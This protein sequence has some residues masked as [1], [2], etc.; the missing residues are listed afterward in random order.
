MNPVVR[1]ILHALTPLVAGCQTASPSL[2]YLQQLKEWMIAHPTEL[3]VLWSS[4]HG[5]NRISGNDAVPGH[6]DTYRMPTGRAT[7]SVAAQRPLSC[8]RL[9]APLELARGARLDVPLFRV[10]GGLALSTPTRSRPCAMARPHNSHGT[11]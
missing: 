11:P 5:D 2:A 4:R 6:G 9:V 3:V 8:R 1:M 10:L 7:T